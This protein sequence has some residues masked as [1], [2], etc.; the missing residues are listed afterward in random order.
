VTGILTEYSSL[1]LPSWSSAL[2]GIYG[3]AYF[4]K[5]LTVAAYPQ[6]PDY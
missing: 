2:P 6:T 4:M 3:L 5:N 1:F